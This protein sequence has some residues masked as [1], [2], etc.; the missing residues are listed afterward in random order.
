MNAIMGF[1]D[2]LTEQYNNKS[3]LE[4]YSSII[5]QRCVDLL[6][7]INEIL[8]IS[9]IESGQLPIHFEECKLNSLLAEISLFFKEN[10]NRLGKQNIKF[11]VHA[12][13]DPDKSVIITD[14]VKLK[15][16]FI[17]LIGNAFKFTEKGSIS[18]G[19]NFVDN[20][21]VFYVSDTGI[22][23]PLDKQGQIFDRFTQLNH[24]TNRLYG[25]TGL[26]L[27][28]VKGLI[29]LLGGEIWLESEPNKGTTFYFTLSYRI[30][31]SVYIEPRTIEQHTN[32]DFTNKSILIV[33]DD[34]YNAEFLKEILVRTGFKIMHTLYGQE[35]IAIAIANSIDMVLMDISLPDMSGYEA[36]Q[37]IRSHKPKLKIIAQTAY[38]ASEDRKK[39]ADAG[40]IDYISKPLKRELLLA[41]INKHLS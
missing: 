25:G 41:M 32:Y 33:E 17:N 40:C 12:H 27:S 37:Q 11:N 9:K 7:I 14:V 30:S 2:L 22:G 36:T 23:I 19:C 21:L 28:I 26:G 3:K 15:Q 24:G 29:N 35:A 4:H 1:A 38:A 8:D 20:K 13:C 18:A 34:I 10:Q 31:D 5:K 6:D 39:A 16:I